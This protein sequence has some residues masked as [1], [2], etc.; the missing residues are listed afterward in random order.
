MANLQI[1]MEQFKFVE[2]TVSLDW[3]NWSFRFEN[4]LHLT[5][6]DITIPAQATVALRH[7]LHAGGP[8]IMD[9][10][11][12]QG[13]LLL[14]YAQFKA[15]LDAR[16]VI[17]ANTLH[18]FTFRNYAQDHE[19][20]FD[21]YVT[22][23]N[24]LAIIAA[25]P[26]ATREREI[27]HVIA[28]NSLDEETR[29]KAF[30]PDITLAQLKAWK[31]AQEVIA[32]CN[33]IVM[34]SKKESDNVNAVRS[35][36]PKQCFNCGN[37]Y[38]HPLGT[39]CPASGKECRRCHKLNHFS[40]VCFKDATKRPYTPQTHRQRFNNNNGAGSSSRESSS[41]SRQSNERNDTNSR[42]RREIRRVK[43]EDMF[44]RFKQFAALDKS[45][46]EDDETPQKKSKSIKREAQSD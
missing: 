31:A 2:N 18:V 3:P 24:R 41:S 23:L 17:P 35:E 28:Q 10:Y 7:R 20:S 37:S 13:N 45:D 12:A 42:Q 9:I 26:A 46:E 33:R 16:F 19:Q 22:M 14:T 25:V 40:K 38:P 44:K 8:K 11:S 39:T 34:K 36:T 15:I 30:T 6:I 4:F 21:D 1:N 32:R 29:N 43:E 5:N 27:L